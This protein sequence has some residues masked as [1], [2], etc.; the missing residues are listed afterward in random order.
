M[1]LLAGLGLAVVVAGCGGSGADDGGG[2]GP[3][4]PTGPVGATRVEVTL[5]DYF[6][7]RPTPMVVAAGV[8]VTFVVSNLGELTHQFYVGDAAAQAARDQEM[9][10][11]DGVGEDSPE[12]IVIPPGE[13][14]EFVV[15]LQSGA[16]IAGCHIPQHYARNMRAN[17]NVVE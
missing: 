13:T 17:I 1:P 16:L 2:G 8:P 11:S 9:A 15:T 10:A 7:I 6:S 12:G 5:T 3:G 14:K 4:E